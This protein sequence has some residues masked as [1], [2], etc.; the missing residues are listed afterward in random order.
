MLPRCLFFFQLCC[1]KWLYS[2]AEIHCTLKY[3]IRSTRPNAT[4][5]LEMQTQKKKG[6]CKSYLYSINGICDTG[7]FSLWCWFLYGLPQQDRSTGTIKEQL[8]AIAPVV[9]Q[10]CKQ[11]EER[12]K[13]FDNTLLQIQKIR[14]E[15]SGTLK[16]GEQVETP[17]VDEEDLSLKKLD[18]Y[19]LQLQELQREKVLRY[20]I[21]CNM[22]WD[23]DVC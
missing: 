14:G 17:V 7:Y 18:E 2:I 9:E 6:N 4:H 1:S 16:L 21:F 5:R 13:E 11:K 23:H 19:K 15:I 3:G 20:I 12:I 8:V 22:F 10:L